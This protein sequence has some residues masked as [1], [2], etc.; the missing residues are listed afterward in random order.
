MTNTVDPLAGS[1][2]VEALTD[3]VEAQAGEYLASGS[4]S[5][6]VLPRPWSS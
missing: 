1:Y 6:A 3:A 4:R 2:Y 5:W